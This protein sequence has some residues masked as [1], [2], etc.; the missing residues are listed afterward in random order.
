ME[1]V[2]VCLLAST[3]AYQLTFSNF[4]RQVLDELSGDL[5]VALLIDEKYDYA[6]P[7]WQHAKY[8][9]TSPIYSDYGDAFDL[10]QRWL[11]Q[12]YSLPPPD[13]RLM[14]QIKGIWQ[15]GIR[16]ADPQESASSILPFCR[17]LLLRGLQQ[18]GIL[19]RYDRFVITRSDFVWLCPHPPLSVLER[20]AIW[21]PNGEC[22]GGVNDRHIVLSRAD[23]VNYLNQIDDILLDPIQL[24]EEMKNHA[25]W[26]NEEFLARHKCYEGM[27][28]KPA[29]NDEQFLAHHLSRKGILDKVKLFPYVMYTARPMHDKSPTWS[30]GRYEPLVGHY[31]KYP[32]EFRIA[33]AYARIIRSR[34]DWENGTWMQ[35][36]PESVTSPISLTRKTYY[37]VVRLLRPPRRIK[38]LI[39]YCKRLMHQI[40]H[41]HDDEV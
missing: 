18:D 8:R 12:E 34:A 28:W 14:L 33:T 15:G 41:R 38:R 4:K 21:L 39:R 10:A 16:S 25:S 29:W 22:Y 2:L 35:F 26:N 30:P 3:R 40:A 7:F 19:D 11:C 23:V 1:R 17:W 31:V 37:N 13:W 20:D 24:Y 32:N 27:N 36:D 5:A 6:N 9:W